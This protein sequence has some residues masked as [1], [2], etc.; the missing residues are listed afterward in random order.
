MAA[1]N[2]QVLQ[3]S[4]IL[5]AA[6][7]GN[8]DIRK[9]AEEQLK[10]W[11]IVPLFYSTLQDIYCDRSIDSSVRLLSIL[12]LKAGIDKYWRK[13][14]KHAIGAEE[15]AKI[16]SKL[17]GF[18]DEEQKKLALQHSVIVAKIARHDYPNEWPDLLHVLLQTIQSTFTSP[19]P[20]RPDSQ[21]PAQQLKLH[22][23][24]IQQRALY[25]L[26]QVIKALCSKK[27]PASQKML[28]QHSPEI[29]RYVSS[30][31]YERVNHV[32][33]CV[34]QILQNLNAV[35]AEVYADVEGALWTALYALKGLRRL[36]VHGFPDF[37][38]HTETMQFFQSLLENLQ[39]FLHLRS[40]VRPNGTLQMLSSKFALLIGKV[41][42][43][44][45]KQRLG[46]FL[47]ASGSI[48]VIKF[49]WSQAEAYT[50]GGGDQMYERFLVQGLV[51]L[52]SLIKNAEFSIVAGPKIPNVDKAKSV[53]DT[54]LFTT[55]FVVSCCEVLVSKYLVLTGEEM[56][57]WEDD[58]ET[59][60]SEEEADHWEYNLRACAEKVLMDLVSQHRALLSPV[61]IQMLQRV[62]EMPD[63]DPRCILLRDAVYSAVGLCAQ[64]LYD[65]VD[66]D[67]WFTGRLIAEAT[68]PS[69]PYRILHRRVALLVGHWVGVKVRKETRPAIYS[70]LLQL[71]SPEEPDL[72]VRLTAIMN[73]KVAVDDWD[74]DPVTFVPYLEKSVAVFTQLVEAVDE[75]ESKM[76]VLN[77]LAMVIERM[78]AQIAPFSQ[79]ITELLPALWA[80]SEGQHLFRSSILVIL[81]RLVTALREPSRSLHPFLT[82]LISYAVNSASPASLYMLEDGL[83]LW[84]ATIQNTDLQTPELLSLYPLAVNLLKYGTDALKKVLKIVESYIVLAPLEVLQVNAN[85]TME[86]ITRLIGDALKPEAGSAVLHCIDVI[87]QSCA[88]A[89]PQPLTSAIHT[90]AASTG[91]ISKIVDTVLQKTELGYIIAGYL[92]SLARMAVNDHI[93]FL[94]VLGSMSGLSD[95]SVSPVSSGGALGAILDYWIEKM[96]G[97]GHAKQRKLTAMACA[98]LLGTGNPI[99]MS[100]IHG[101]FVVLSSAVSDMKDSDHNGTDALVWWYDA[102]EEDEDEASPDA[103]RRKSLL[104]RDPV[105]T[106]ALIPFIR[107]RMN[108]AAATVG[109]PVQFRQ[110]L[111]QSVD[112]TIL[113][114][115]DALMA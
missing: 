58:P 84:L 88:A 25:T 100:R 42:T 35:P 81:T 69:P 108:A 68:N 76:K 19:S 115:M 37:E 93:F 106:T 95:G 57:S 14:A 64:D 86:S 77:S 28:E 63:T 6:N 94:N 85:S 102:R 16:R 113:E 21:L 10:A 78:E 92:T 80:S 101:I 40:V 54:E 52:K 109:G 29:F 18:F 55:T 96:D 56:R 90:V 61:L 3:L 33:E 38:Q 20:P 17:L 46:S 79:R 1:N 67:S 105:H 110:G 49:Y 75:F 114:A 48:S 89:Q 51:L 23:R 22:T 59:F 9:P 50:P 70:L 31:Y 91:L 43:D 2:Q 97:M 5:Q 32:M 107:D 34:P 27:L 41:Y 62:S 13:T 36:L 39:K 73:L 4:A 66:F 71:A 44:L 99:V 83:E 30:I 47:L 104:A 11:E 7:S 15:K 45:E 74:F 87:L 111:I 112:P 24:L 60:V 65:L 26:H 12:Y 98:T 103:R 72:A 82:P 8:P 53:I